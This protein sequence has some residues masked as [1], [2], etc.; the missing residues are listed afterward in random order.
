M[1]GTAF[2]DMTYD[3]LKD[4]YTR[5]RRE[6]VTLLKDSKLPDEAIKASLED[7][8]AIDLIIKET[9]EGM[10]VWSVLGNLLFSD[11]RTATASMKE[12]QILEGLASND[13]F[14][15]AAHLRT[16]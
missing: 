2:K 4:R 14:V 1:S 13:I 5:I 16:M 10:T 11:N 8:Y 6:V 3:G 15:K 12:Q 9:G 7:L